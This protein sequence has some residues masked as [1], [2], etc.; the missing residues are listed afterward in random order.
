[1]NE[2]RTGVESTENLRWEGLSSRRIKPSYSGC[3]ELAG[4]PGGVGI[5]YEPLC[6]LFF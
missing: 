4:L 5:L 6:L 3:L 2:V 1:M